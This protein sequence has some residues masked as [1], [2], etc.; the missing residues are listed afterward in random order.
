MNLP[1]FAQDPFHANQLTTHSQRNAGESCRLVFAP[2]CLRDIKS[3]MFVDS[4][5]ARLTSRVLFS[6]ARV[7][8]SDACSVGSV[9]QSCRC[10]AFHFVLAAS[11]VFIKTRRLPFSSVGSASHNTYTATLSI[12]FPRMACDAC[13]NVNRGSTRTKKKARSIKSAVRQRDVAYLT[14]DTYI[15]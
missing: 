2:G 4:S 9:Y 8:L 14:C 7:F 1:L 13:T 6:P 5:I 11:E 10:G 15:R 12:S 3:V